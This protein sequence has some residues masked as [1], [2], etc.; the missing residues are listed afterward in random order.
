MGFAREEVQ[1]FSRSL[2]QEI[3]VDLGYDLVV[4]V[5]KLGWKSMFFFLDHA[6]LRKGQQL[7]D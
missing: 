1:S 5:Y 7:S 4:L 2:W 6:A 3:V